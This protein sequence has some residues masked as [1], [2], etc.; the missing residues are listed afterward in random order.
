[1]P[2]D[3]VEG[4]RFEL[5]GTHPEGHRRIHQDRRKVG[6]I[7]EVTAVERPCECGCGQIISSRG[8]RGRIKRFLAGHWLRKSN[9]PDDAT[10]ARLH[11]EERISSSEIARRYGVKWSTCREWLAQ[12]GVRVEDGKRRTQHVPKTKVD[13]YPGGS[14]MRRLYLD[15]KL[16]TAGIG[17]RYGVAAHTASRWVKRSGIAIR[18]TNEAR[19][20]FYNKDRPSDDD[21][22]RMYL[23]EEMSGSEIGRVLGVSI[24]TGLEWLKEA[25]VPIRS[26]SETVRAWLAKR[27]RKPQVYSYVPPRTRYLV[28]ARDEFRCL[29]CGRSPRV[30]GV[31]LHVDHIHPA[32]KG[33]GYEI[34]NLQTL[35]AECNQGKSDLIL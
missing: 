9:R 12:A 13:R 20:L 31:I 33:G 11:T 7:T 26:R 15:E 18:P 14:E 8:S 27:P 17:E 4:D 3:V 10:L 24:Y 16:S 5:V 32:S 34:E 35:C 23:V 19:R 28:L 6:E 29:A 30:H 1:M 21:L 22:K 2:Q 25:G